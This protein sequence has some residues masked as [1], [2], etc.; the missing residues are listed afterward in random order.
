MRPTLIPVFIIALLCSTSLAQTTKR[1]GTVSKPVVATPQ[2]QP[3]AQPPA[4]ARAAMPQQPTALVI[5]NG[6]TFTTADLQPTLRQEMER[7]ENKIAQ[8]RAAVLDL[9]IN[10]MLLQVEAKKRRID[11]RRLY[12]L[13]VSSRVPAITPAQIKKFIDDNR[14]Q[15]EGLDPAAANK[16]V[17]T[18]LR[19][20]AETKLADELAKRLRQT[21]SVVMGVDINS[22]NISP[23]AVIATV[24]GEPLKAD[25]LLERLKP[26]IYRIRIDAYEQAKQQTDRLV[27]DMLLLEEARRRQI[28]PEEIIR[29]EI[30]DKVKSPT[31]QEV[32]KFYA[33]NKARISGD[34]N[35]VRNQV[36]SY[37]QEQSR[38]QLEKELSGRLRK[39]ANVR[40]LLI[41]PEQPIQNVSVD[42]DPTRGDVNAPVTV[43]EF[44]DF[45]CP[46][47]A[48]MHPVLDEVLKS[49]GN[50]VRFVVR[51]FPLTQHENAQKAAEAANAAHAQG[52]FFEYASLLF[53]NQ[54]ALDVVSLKK[55]AT[56]L[57]LNR[58]RF[59]AEL[60]RGVYAA[61]VKKDLDDGEIYGV[62][63]TPTVFIN[64]IQLKTLS[65]DG[66]REAINRAV[67][68]G[69]KPPGR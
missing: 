1:R 3:A 20:E 4:T 60:D 43:V 36:A 29:A 15:L 69:S 68:N 37:L 16:Q 10:T 32:A 55:Y 45:Q 5:V 26:V 44:T 63:S 40:W 39:N 46:A 34:L 35:S 41:E 65:A 8:A 52:K 53:K 47:C 57:G 11:T 24:G 58:A 51:D 50:K 66:L 38:Q 14:Q 30:T 13:E 31:E 33:D 7:L 49:Y 17:E 48:A 61:E 64:G 21:H 59:D 27:D 25:S 67:A 12:E 9:Q 56:D 28:G 2:P 19:E 6:Q 62:G 18:F 54:K 22:A 23:S 42:D